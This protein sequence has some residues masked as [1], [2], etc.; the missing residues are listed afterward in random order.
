MNDEIETVW[1]RADQERAQH[2]TRR[3]W[4]VLAGALVLLICAVSVLS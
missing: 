3:V 1:G 4:G 2:N